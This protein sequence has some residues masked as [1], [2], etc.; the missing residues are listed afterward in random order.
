MATTYR[1]GA[2]RARPIDPSLELLERLRFVRPPSAPSRHSRRRSLYRATTRRRR[3]RRG[4]LV[5]F[6]PRRRLTQLM[7][8]S[9]GCQLANGVKQVFYIGF[10][11]F[12]LRRD[13]DNAVANDGDENNNT[14][15]NIPSDLEQVPA[16][17]NFLRGTDNAGTA[18]NIDTT[19]WGD[20]RNTTYTNDTT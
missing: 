3:A 15:T 5:E 18:G 16:L 7:G 13:N 17:Y 11:N 1:K 19:N 20:G 8:T 6:R 14:N 10:D 2:E 4:P 9:S 12:H